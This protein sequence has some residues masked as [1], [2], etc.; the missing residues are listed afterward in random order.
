MNKDN[1][2]I[3]INLKAKLLCLCCRCHQHNYHHNHCCQ[4]CRCPVNLLISGFTFNS[5]ILVFFCFS[6]LFACFAFW[7]WIRNQFDTSAANACWKFSIFASMDITVQCYT[8]FSFHTHQIKING[9]AQLFRFIFMQLPSLGA[10]ACFI[11][12][13]VFL[14]FLALEILLILLLSECDV[15]VFLFFSLLPFGC[16]MCVCVCLYCCFLHNL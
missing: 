12:R 13:F 8:R 9:I 10:A 4:H 11:L 2:S 6:N 1:T 5:P 3:L 15:N 7:H 14:W 16:S